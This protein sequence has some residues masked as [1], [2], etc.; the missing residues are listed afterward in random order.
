LSIR[1]PR[2]ELR[3]PDDQLIVE[4]VDASKRGIHDP[5]HMPFGIPWTDTKSPEFERASLQHHWGSRA[6]HTADSWG[7]GF[8]VLLDG[9]AVGAQGCHADNF[10]KLRVGETGSWLG[11]EFQGQGIGKEMRAAVLHFF[12]EGL[13]ATQMISGAWHDNQSSLGVSRAMGYVD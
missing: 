10:A 5:A 2:I 7:F 4:L 1:T 11:R 12:F 13:G 9:R 8:A 6:R 3:Y